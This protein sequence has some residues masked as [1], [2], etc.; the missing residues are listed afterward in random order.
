MFFGRVSSAIRA[1]V[2]LSAATIFP[3]FGILVFFWVSCESV[4]DQIPVR[5]FTSIDS[6]ELGM[7]SL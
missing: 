1:K 3:K 6:T 4:N 2:D 7:P 5:G